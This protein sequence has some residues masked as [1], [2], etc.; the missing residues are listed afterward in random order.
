MMVDL[1]AIAKRSFIR[2]VAAIHIPHS[3]HILLGFD[4]AVG[5][6]LTA[7]PPESK[8]RGFGS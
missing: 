4:G 7:S 8:R 3:V 5:K 2:T 1:L 6:R